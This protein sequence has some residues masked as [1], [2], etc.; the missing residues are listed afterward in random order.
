M[1][2]LDAMEN[3]YA[4]PEALR[5]EVAAAAAGA[6]LNRYPDPGAARLKARLEAAMG[7][8]GGRGRAARQRVGRD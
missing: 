4:L 1:V 6:A 3:P 7:V 2:K 8:P 5:A